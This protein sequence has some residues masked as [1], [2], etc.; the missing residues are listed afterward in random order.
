MIGVVDGATQPWTLVP[1]RQRRRRSLALGGLLLAGGTLEVVLAEWSGG[2]FIVIGLVVLLA[3]RIRVEVS[4]T[5]LVVRGRVGRR[6]VPLAD[7]LQ[8]GLSPTR[9][10]WVRPRSSRPFFVGPLSALRGERAAEPAEFLQMLRQRAE[11]AGARLDPT[12]G[13]RYAEAPADIS[14]FF[15]Q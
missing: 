8:V 3:V 15:G 6:R 9:G 7:L 5:E 12:S 10:A 2:A 1:T 11:A 14:P 13:A 4:D